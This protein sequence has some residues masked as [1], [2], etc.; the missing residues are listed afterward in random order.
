MNDNVTTKLAAIL[1]TLAETGGAPES[2][3]YLG[4]NSNLDEWARLKYVLMDNGLCSIVFDYMTLTDKGLKLAKQ[5]EAAI[6][7]V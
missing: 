1:T 3:I 5:I 2:I 4:V 6:K 7:G